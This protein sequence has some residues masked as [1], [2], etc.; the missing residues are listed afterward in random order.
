[1]AS[2]DR[3][4]G[5][6][7]YRAFKVGPLP[8]ER[9]NRVLGTELD[10]ADVWI[11]KACHRHIAEDHPVDYEIIMANIVEIV[12]DPTWIGQDPRHSA[13]FYLVKR[14]VADSK[15]VPAILV[16]IG[17]TLNAHGTYS[18]KSAYRISQADIDTRRL[19]K[20]LHPAPPG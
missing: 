7:S 5:E 15:D 19:R 20:S 12:A 16:A 6:Q 10:P 1:M 18:A 4:R 8:A 2:G 17:L 3:D 9:V 11:S 13:N 14:I